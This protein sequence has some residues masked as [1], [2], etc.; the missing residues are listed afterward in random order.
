MTR[1]D[2]LYAAAAGAT[3]L[4]AATRSRMGIATTCYMTVWKPKDT[5]EFLE[6]A[7]AVG[8]GGIQ[9]ALSSLEP[10][11]LRKLRDRAVDAGMYIEVMS[12]M[13]RRDDTSAF[14]RTVAAAKQVGALCLRCACLGGRRYETFDTLPAWQE[15]AAA[16]RIAIDRAAGIAE[17]EK[18]PLAIENHKDWTAE[19]LAA[20][21]KSRSSEYLGVCLDTGN[22]IALLDDPLAVVETLAPYAISTHIKDM[23]VR[24]YADGFLLSEI[25]LGDGMLDIQR[26]VATIRKARPETR[27]TLEMITRDPLHVP[28]LTEKYWKTFPDRGG[29]FLARTLRMVRSRENQRKLPSLAGLDRAAQLRLEDDNV[30][31]CLQDAGIE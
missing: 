16:S 22:N 14:E 26:V 10:A 11:Y 25:P 17:R 21:M 19:E 13:P 30:R 8:A 4:V 27:M 1:R 31:R 2:F 12:A 28:C 23:D 9:A 24:E 3:P 5:L 15:H 20:I 29:E 6:H 18:L 7:V